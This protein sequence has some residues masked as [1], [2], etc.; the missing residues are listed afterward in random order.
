M[1]KVLATF[2]TLCILLCVACQ[3]TPTEEA[4]LSRADGNLERAI[5][6]NPVDPYSYDAP[7]LWEETYIVRDQEIR[8]LADIDLPDARQYPV[9]T[10]KQR[11][12]S[13]NDVLSFLQSLS[14][15]EWSVRDN[16]YSLDELFI[17]LQNAIKGQ[18]GGIDY[19]TGEVIWV[20]YE[21]QQEDIERL[22]QLISVTPTEDNYIL[23]NPTKCLLPFDRQRMKNEEGE[24]WYV[25]GNER[26]ITASR[27]RDGVVQM[28]NWV[29]QGEATPGE[30]PHALTDICISEKDALAIGDAWINALGLKDFHVSEIQKARETQSYTY[31]VLGEG[32]WLT[33]VPSTAGAQPCF[34]GNYVD[35]D[36]LNFTKNEGITYAPEWYQE[37]IQMFVTEDGISFLSWSDP[38]EEV[39]IANKNVVLLPFDVFQSNLK[40]LIE[41]G[42]GTNKCSPII[43][44]R[45]V[46]TTSIAQIP[47]QGN[48]AFLV[49]TWAVFLTSELNESLN[50]DMGVL[51]INAIDGTYINRFGSY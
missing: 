2:L 26:I 31:K 30:L 47:N 40:K 14:P 16:E 10:I 27:H 36:F 32:F 39:M 37:N 25:S 15:G 35:P 22:Q 42:I 7:E 43:V 50:I 11:S 24:T 48:E 19:E 12:F 38:K 8:F 1:K 4:V 17:D 9:I 13:S 46:L 41:Y 29:L 3:P 6:S 45:I 28:E 21:G 23:F 5:T 44:S 49:P 33:Y 51:L 20:P 18:Y 34:Y